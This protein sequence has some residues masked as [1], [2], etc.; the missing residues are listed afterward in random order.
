M[1]GPHFEISAGSETAHDSGQRSDS[2]LVSLLYATHTRRFLTST[3]E[4]G[5]SS[6]LVGVLPV[7]LQ[8]DQ[9]YAK[10]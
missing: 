5:R 6:L 10:R 8:R 3:S 7:Q 2:E 4:V 9:F 1:A